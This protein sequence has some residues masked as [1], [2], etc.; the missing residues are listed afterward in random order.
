ME[1]WIL[2]IEICLVLRILNLEFPPKV[3]LK[4]LSLMRILVLGN[5]QRSGVQQEA[6][7]LLPLLRSHCQIAVFDLLQTESLADVEADLAVVLGGDGAIL[8]AARQMGY[9]QVPVLGINLG[10]LGFL[11]DVSAEDVEDVLPSILRREFQIVQHLMFECVLQR[12]NHEDQTFLGLNETTIRSG[13][14]YSVVDLELSIDGESVSRYNGD[15]LIVS[16]PIGSTAHN[17]SAGGPILVQDQFAFVITPLGPHS[18]T[19]R[20][21]VDSA[22]K[23]YT[24]AVRHSFGE[25]ALV[26]DGQEPISITPEH[27]IVL[28]KAPVTFGLVKV[29]GHSYYQTLRNKLRWGLQ[30][31]YRED[32]S[33]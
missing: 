12:P 14:P 8:R 26:I 6:D 15:G 18:L 33:T 22:E 21:L 31:N 16:T 28:R 32:S 9:R 11:A 7:R 17:L 25:T 3:A 4:R 13:P 1:F 23:V 30:P 10:T 24:I 29:A 27:R 5:A 2:V 19:H 20:P